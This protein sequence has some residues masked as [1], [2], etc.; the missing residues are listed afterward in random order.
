M[1]HSFVLVVLS[2]VCLVTAGDL[3]TADCRCV[4]CLWTFFREASPLI[5]VLGSF[6]LMLAL[7][8]RLGCA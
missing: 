7:E 3:G 1:R 4:R 2:V 5:I 8:R 6:R